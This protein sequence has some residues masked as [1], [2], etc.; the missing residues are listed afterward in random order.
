MGLNLAARGQLVGSLCKRHA[1]TASLPLR[2]VVGARFQGLFHSPRGVLFTFP[3]RYWFAIG[4]QGVFSLGGWSRLFRAGFHVPRATRDAGWPAISLPVRG[5]HPL[6][7]AFPGR[8]G[9][10]RSP[11]ADPTTPPGPRPRRFGLLPFRSPLLGESLACFLLLPLLRCFSSRRS[12]TSRCRIAA[13]FPHSDTPGSR[14]VCASPG[15]FAACRVLRRLLEPGH[16]PCALVFF[17][18]GAA[19]LCAPPVSLSRMSMCVPPLCGAWWKWRSCHSRACR[20]GAS[21][22]GASRP[23]RKEVF[24][25]HLPVRLP[26]YDLAPVIRFALGRSSRSRPSGAPDSH[27]LTGG[28]YKARERIHRAMADARLLANPASRGRVADPGPN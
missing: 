2:Q 17:S 4:L 25:P 1:V 10:S 9:S 3:S 12:P 16:P 21:P 6:W 15:S 18:S 23:S 8:S 19:L 13:G 7:P 22:A 27:G 14:A 28:V 5:C 26:C 20:R 24:Q 11:F